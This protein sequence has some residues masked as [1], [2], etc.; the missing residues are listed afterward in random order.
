[1]KIKLCLLAVLVVWAFAPAAHAA[2]SAADEQMLSTQ[3]SKKVLVFRTFYRYSDR[4]DVNPDG[5]IKGKYKQGYWSVDGNVQVQSVD[6]SKDRVSFKCAKLWADERNDG[7]LHFFPASAAL[8]GKSDYSESATISFKLDGT[9][10]TPEAF[11][12]EVEKVFLG[13]DERPLTGCPRA[14]AAYIS[15]TTPEVEYDPATGTGTFK[16]T[17]PKALSTPMLELSREAQ[18]VGQKGKQTFALLVDEKGNAAVT[19]FTT[20][21][22]YGLEDNTL[23]AVKGWKFQPGVKDGQPVPVVML[24]TVEYKEPMKH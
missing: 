10:S 11:T 16:G 6:F 18:L 7:G 2:F 9:N 19:A 5:T 23:E 13:P 3:Y 12:K 15:K 20:V 1:M 22:N 24:M 4:L 17:P 8:K 14:I 21:L